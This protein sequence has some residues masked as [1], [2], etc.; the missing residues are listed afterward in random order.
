MRT[1]QKLRVI[2]FKSIREQELL[3]R[4]L[5][6]FIGSTGSGKS[7]L[8]GVFSFLKEI[9]AQNLT[10]YTRL[11]AGADTL[12]YYGRKRSPQM[13]IDVEFGEG[14]TTNRYCI[15]LAGAIDD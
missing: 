13:E 12:L 7:N 11:K 4:P 15:R 2:N 6:V 1:L 14:N 8:I 9:V 3:L 5:N 10:R